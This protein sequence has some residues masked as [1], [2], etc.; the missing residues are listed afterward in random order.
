VKQ[1]LIELQ[2]LEEY[3][4]RDLSNPLSETDRSSRQKI[5]KDITELNR[6]INQ[7]DTT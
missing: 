7:L 1:K 4:I 6:A 5:S 3:I 2:K